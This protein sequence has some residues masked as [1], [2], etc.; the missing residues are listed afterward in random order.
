LLLFALR[1]LQR[2]FGRFG[3]SDVDRLVAHLELV[4]AEHELLRRRLRRGD[5]RFGAFLLL[6]RCELFFRR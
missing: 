3:G 2:A 5:F 6:Q 1:R 4:V